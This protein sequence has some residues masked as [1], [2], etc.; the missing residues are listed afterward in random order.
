MET[1]PEGGV[2]SGW[3][4]A[5]VGIQQQIGWV[6]DPDS[7]RNFLFW[8]GDGVDGEPYN[9][10]S[11]CANRVQTQDLWLSLTNTP[12]KP[13]IANDHLSS[14][15]CWKLFGLPTGLAVTTPIDCSSSG[16]SHTSQR[17]QICE[18]IDLAVGSGVVLNGHLQ[19][20]GTWSTAPDVNRQCDENQNHSVCGFYREYDTGG[21]AATTTLAEQVT[22]NLSGFVNSVLE[23]D[24]DGLFISAVNPA[25]GKMFICWHCIYQQFDL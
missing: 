25:E 10:A 24:R 2:R 23:A 20:R 8:R 7:S 14:M 5:K 13:G 18:P 6:S 11:D 1:G 17:R 16:G 19:R 3:I 21:E 4:G 15:G 12:R 9:A 22:V